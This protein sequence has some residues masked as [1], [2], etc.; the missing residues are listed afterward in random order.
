MN[1]KTGQAK[2]KGRASSVPNKSRRSP[3]SGRGKRQRRV[4]AKFPVDYGELFLSVNAD[5]LAAFRDYLSTFQQK[6]P[7]CS[8]ARQYV[9]RMSTLMAL[10]ESR[11]DGS[12]ALLSNDETT[13]TEG[14]FDIPVVYD[15][16]ATPIERRVRVTKPAGSGNSGSG[17]YAQLNAN[18]LAQFAQTTTSAYRVKSVESWTIGGESCLVAVQNSSGSAGTEILGASASNY[19]RIGEGF[20]GMLTSFPLGALPLYLANETTNIVGHN[21]GSAS[22]LQVVFDV[23]LECLI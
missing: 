1:N 12:V 6:Y 14:S 8:R 3:K 21:V 13:M 20:C 5:K 10:Y 23:I 16:G 15:N 4:L 22:G 17:F 11:M 19:T 2:P 18:D 9:K 7:T